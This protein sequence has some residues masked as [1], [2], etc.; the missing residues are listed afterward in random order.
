MIELVVL[1]LADEQRLDAVLEGWKAAGASG[2]TILESTGLGKVHDLLHR[3]DLPL[4]P[5][6]RDL[7]QEEQVAHCTL[8]TV[9]EGEALIDRLVAATVDVV[10]D[11]DQDDV[12]ILFTLPIGRAYGIKPH[13]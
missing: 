12:G 10:G 13:S 7:L 6:L 4:F 3:D 8:F 9:A 1:V 11:L 2:I 5:S